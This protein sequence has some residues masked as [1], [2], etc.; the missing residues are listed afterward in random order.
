MKVRYVLSNSESRQSITSLPVGAVGSNHTD[1]LN[2]TR[3]AI[4]DGAAADA[5]DCNAVNQISASIM[6]SR[7]DVS[8]KEAECVRLNGRISK[9]ANFSADAERSVNWS[10]LYETLWNVKLRWIKENHG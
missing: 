7:T 5:V 6:S 1:N 8:G 3:S 4:Q 10:K 9:P 2:T